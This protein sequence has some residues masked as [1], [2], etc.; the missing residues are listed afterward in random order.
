[1][2]EM[3]DSC[4]SSAGAG[5]LARRGVSP[6]A[7]RGL[8]GVIVVSSAACAHHVRLASPD[9]DPGAR[10][11]CSADGVCHPDDSDVPADD[12]PSNTTQ[13]T[14]PRECNGR[15]HQLLIIDAG[16]S[17]PVL[18]VTCAPAEEP[19]GTMGEPEARNALPAA[20]E[21]PIER[22]LSVEREQPVAEER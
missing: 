18:R 2:A 12:N 3:I 11:V 9:T 10:Y 14:L 19:V 5:A 4:S 15:Y 17:H 16:S 22:E 13:L 8:L 7:R 20:S 6:L 21:L 1:M